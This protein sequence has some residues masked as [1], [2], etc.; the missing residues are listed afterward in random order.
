[1]KSKFLLLLGILLIWMTQYSY[2]QNYKWAIGGGSTSSLMYSTDW[3]QVTHMCTDANRNIYVTTTMGDDNITADTFFMVHAFNPT[4][5]GATPTPHI[6]IASYNPDGKI[7]WGKLL[8]AQ[9]FSRSY[10]IAYDNAG[11]IYTIGYLY[12]NNKHL[13]YDTVITSTNLTSFIVKYDTSGKFKWIRFIGID[14]LKT[15]F[16]TGFQSAIA[17]DGLGFIHY[18]SLIKNGVQITSTLTSTTGTYDL[19]YDSLGNLTHANKI[20]VDSNE[21]FYKVIF[22]KSSGVSY[23]NIIAIEPSTGNAKGSYIEAFDTLDKKIWV[24]SA[25]FISAQVSDIDYDGHG[26]IYGAGVG[27]L[28]PFYIGGDTA[29]SKNISTNVC[30]IFRLDTLGNLKWMRK[31]EGT[32][33]RTVDDIVALTVTSAGFVA[34]CGTMVN[35]AIDGTDSIVTP[36]SEGWN[37][38]LYIL[39]TAGSL[40]KL[41]QLHGDAFYDLAKSITSDRLGNIYI[42]GFVGDSI[43]TKGI[44]AYRNSGGETDFFVVKYGYSDG[45]TLTT[46]PTPMFSVSG[47]STHVPATVTF[48]YA[49]AN[50]PDSVKWVFGDGIT[51]RS[52]NPSHTYTDTG[53]MQVCL[54]VYGCD[55]GTYC[56]YITTLQPTSVSNVKVFPGL[57]VYPNPANDRL[58]VGNIDIGTSVQIFDLVGR[59][60]Y[61]TT[62][63]ENRQIIDVHELQAGVYVLQLTNKLGQKETVRFVKAQ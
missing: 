25:S 44:P 9:Y 45:C 21:N 41:D 19:I 7:R 52:L 38:L 15:R 55:S 13:G 42:G 32:S 12:G 29:R 30:A 14:D 24:D 62:T 26:N 51:S 27:Q 6:F 5:C 37:P 1:M 18:Y 50:T 16:N 11:N 61:A 28:Q 63:T 2:A 59:Q 36:N 33:Y 58:T 17:V 34:G 57:Q 10:G 4:C 3:E 47:D 8:D 54:T 23:A 35:A 60:M 46:E 39:D 40:I 53:I 31:L 56:N 43:F 48:T 49:G 20:S 22:N